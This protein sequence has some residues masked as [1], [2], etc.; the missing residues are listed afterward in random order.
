MESTGVTES[1]HA[2]LR[3]PDSV[4]ESQVFFSELRLRAQRQVDLEVA[5][6]HPLGGKIVLRFSQHGRQ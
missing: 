4:V 1:V 2:H 6:L 3:L 5:V